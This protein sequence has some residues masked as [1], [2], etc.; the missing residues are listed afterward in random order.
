MTSVS[1]RSFVK[2]ALSGGA[3]AVSSLACSP[4]DSAGKTSD[5]Q[6]PPN[7]SLPL[8]GSWLFRT[9]Q[10]DIG[11]RDKWFEKEIPDADWQAVEVPH[12]WQVMDTLEEY[13]GKAWYRC[14][15]EAPE[16]GDDSWVRLEFEAVFHSAVVWLNGVR[17]GE[18]LL[19]GYTA[20]TV[21]L[22]RNSGARPD[23]FLAVEVDN[24]FHDR[25]LSRNTS[26]D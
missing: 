6:E 25:M 3:L 17:V 4:G 5:Q 22:T 18:H 10:E 26:Y 16:T 11:Q 2:E 12:T 14:A 13:S 21:D 24:S 1:R 20:F 8:K 9:D 19:K 7:Y 23:N 15:F